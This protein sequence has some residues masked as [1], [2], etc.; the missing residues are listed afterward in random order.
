MLTTTHSQHSN[1]TQGPCVV[2]AQHMCY[3]GFR[4]APFQTQHDTTYVSCCQ[5]HDSNTVLKSVATHIKFMW[6]CDKSLAN[7]IRSE[8]IPKIEQVDLVHKLFQWPPENVTNTCATLMPNLKIEKTHLQHMCCVEK[9]ANTNTCVKH[10]KTHVFVLCCCHP[11]IIY[12]NTCFNNNI[13]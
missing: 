13:F 9:M 5:T 8:G 7:C 4:A 2:F 10:R 1:T 6:F 12:I 3:D 11:W